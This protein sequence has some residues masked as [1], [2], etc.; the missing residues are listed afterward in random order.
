MVP[1]RP[2]VVPLRG[3]RREWS[4][5]KPSDGIADIYVEQITNVFE[6]DVKYVTSCLPGKEEQVSSGK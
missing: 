3:M 5:S 2:M 1:L 6:N 4:R